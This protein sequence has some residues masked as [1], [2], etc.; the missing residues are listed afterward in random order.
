MT[1]TNI[2]RRTVLRGAG[3]CM[4]L[5]F[6][7]A[8][9][10]S[11]RADEERSARQ[12]KT[13]KRLATFS[14][15]FGVVMD[16][17]HPR[18]TGFNYVMPESLA[19][20]SEHREHFT[21]FTNAEHGLKGGHSA[22]HTFLSGIKQSQKGNFPDGNITIDQRVSEIVGHETRFPH[23]NFWEAGMSYTR[24]GVRVPSIV[25]PSDAFRLLF[26]DATKSEIAAKRVSLLKSGSIL[27]AVLAD[28]NRFNQKLGKVDREKMDEYFTSVRG[29]E[30]KLQASEGWLDKKKPT[31]STSSKTMKGI[32]NGDYDVSLAG[33]LTEAWFEIM[34]LALQTDS[35]RVVST[36]IGN[37]VWGLDGVTENFH[38]L[39]HHGRRPEKLAQ[40]QIIDTYLMT[41]LAKFLGHLRDAKELDGR[42]MLDTTQVLFGSGLGNGQHTNKNLPIVLAGGSF[43]HGQHIDNESKKPLCNLYLKMLQQF[44]PAQEKFNLSDGAS[45]GSFE[46]KV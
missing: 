28:A 29:T 2:T 14:V 20:M 18:E 15:P 23:L 5:P 44:S 9:T 43:K 40:L 1:D 38:T 24:S 37:C 17:F 21:C 46:T 19:P 22:N 7:E 26:V 27:D 33:P 34:F 35:T 4:A 11:V 6:L 45:I 10:P 42:S 30:K 36:A 12:N 39:S 41:Y 3:V 13:C 8:M 16:K 25:K 31:L 32:V